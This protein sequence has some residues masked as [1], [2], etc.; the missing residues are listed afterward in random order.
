M[1]LHIS[2]VRFIISLSILW[3]LGIEKGAESNAYSIHGQITVLRILM[4]CCN[5][6]G[7]SSVAL[8][9]WMAHLSDGIR[10]IPR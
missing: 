4:F 2:L 9:F 3:M 8:S 6:V 10:Q 7:E 5:D 1:I